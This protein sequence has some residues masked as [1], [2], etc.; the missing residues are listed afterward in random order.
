[1]DTPPATYGHALQRRRAVK[2]S[3][4]ES[5]RLSKAIRDVDAHPP[6][7]TGTKPSFISRGVRNAA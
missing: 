3:D 5:R 6:V 1:M 4:R 7:A 2:I